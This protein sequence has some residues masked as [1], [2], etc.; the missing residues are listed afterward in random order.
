MLEFYLAHHDYHFIM[1]FVEQL[2]KEAV[3]AS[4]QS[5]T[6]A[7]GQEMIDF[8][9]PFKRISVTDAVLEVCKL[10]ASE[11][12]DAKIDELITKFF[13]KITLDKPSRDIKI[14]ALFEKIVEPTL[15]QPTFIT[16]YPIEISPL[17]KKD[18]DNPRVA[19]RYE[20]F[21]GGMEISNG[22]NELNDPYDQAE[23]FKQQLEA[24]RAGDPEAHQYD[25]DYIQALEYGLAPTVG[26]GI[27][28]DR[29][30]ML[31]TNTPSIK[32]VILFPT[33]KKK[34]HASI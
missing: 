7:F 6:V 4:C 25:A 11:L 16:H 17:A 14:Y 13:I 8:S 1:G 15:I 19:A 24:H 23:R 26:V 32:D 27:G 3:H 9:K 20:L 28:I 34:E 22:F 31:L 29:L 10:S 30:V 2:I 18:P 12:T 33:L 5:M 21:I